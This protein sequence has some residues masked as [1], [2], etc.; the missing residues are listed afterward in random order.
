ALDMVNFSSQGPVQD[1]RAKPDIVAPSTH[2]QGAASQDSFF[3]TN[4][5][6]GVCDRYFP[7][8][9]TLYTWSSGTSHSTPLV[10]GGAALAY[11]SLQQSLGSPPSPALVKAFILN[12]TSYLTGKLAGDN[13]PGA[14]QGW[15]LLN[16]QRMF[17]PVDRIIYDQSP[18]RTFT[19][20]DG[21]P[22]QISGVISDPGNEFRVMLSWTDAPGD[23]A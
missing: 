1:G 21:T 14:R 9:Q 2:I 8:G 15:G 7:P 3:A 18:E 22:F 19:E 5:N 23:A 17:A 20:S 11:Q 4:R 16:L 6:L 12:S 13:L 10:A